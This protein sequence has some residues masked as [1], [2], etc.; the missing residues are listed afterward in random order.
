MRPGLR[1]A[2]AAGAFVVATLAGCAGEG[3]LRSEAPQRLA[4]VG[5]LYVTAKVITAS[6][7]RAATAFAVSTAA[8]E[9]L[10]RGEL[11]TVGALE[12]FALRELGLDRLD[13]AERVAAEEVVRII[14][15]EL[16][17]AALLSGGGEHLLLDEVRRDAAILLGQVRA[18]AAGAMPA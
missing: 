12:A 16:R 11:M 18:I 8:L 1:R 9:A 17:R 13:V 7:D 10:T 2:L 3:G 6:P 4:Q 14:A 5:V 15:D